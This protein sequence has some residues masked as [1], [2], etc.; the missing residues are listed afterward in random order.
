MSKRCNLLK[1]ESRAQV[2]IEYLVIIGLSFAILVP[3]GYFFYNYSQTSNEAAIRSQVTQIGTAML[4][5]AE[6]VYGLAD[7]SLVTLDVT[8]PRNIRDIYILDNRE[9][10]IKYELSSGMNEAVFYSKV[11]ISGDYTYPSRTSCSDL[12][13]GS[14]TISGSLPQQGL[15][16]VRFDSK[17]TYVHMTLYDSGTP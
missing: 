12:P 2:S 3:A 16:K 10:V 13:C 15:H 8:Y 11:D 17:T 14:S 1:D 6:S 9:L 5:S 7:G 4:T